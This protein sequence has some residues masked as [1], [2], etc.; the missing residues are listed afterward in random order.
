MKTWKTIWT[1]ARKELIDIF[2][3]RRTTMLTLLFSPLLFP[4]LLLGVGAM[5]EKRVK[6]QLEESLDLPVLGAEHAPNL[7]KFLQTQNIKVVPAPKDIDNAVVS[8]SKDIVLKISPDYP[9][10]WRKGEAASVELVFD[11]SR[12]NAML[13]RQRLETVLQSYSQSV[14]QLRLLSRGVAPG[15]TRGVNIAHRDLATPAAKRSGILNFMMP[16]ILLITAFLGSAALIMDAT[17]G[18]RERQSLEPL[19][20]TPASRE[21]IMSG[22]I[23]GSFIF[24]L[25]GLALIIISLGLTFN[26]GGSSAFKDVHVGGMMLLQL[27]LVQVP[28]VLIGATLLTLIS[29]SVKSLKEAQ[30][31]MAILML[32]PMIPSFVLA[33][34]PMKNEL[35]QFAVPFLAQNQMILKLIRAETIQLNEWLVYLGAG[36]GLSAV[37]WFIAA[38]MYHREKLAISA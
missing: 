14:S 23:F 15:S 28:L 4:A 32:M 34:S 22:K 18:E 1:V 36:F 38:R 12:E 10:Q 17:A 31:Y 20:A 16:Y 9:N 8:Q 27:L 37:L 24:G 33:A 3:D 35:W 2:R 11:S 30:S 26:F 21:A 6:T 29:A 25:I 13:V 19:L 7:I 5:A